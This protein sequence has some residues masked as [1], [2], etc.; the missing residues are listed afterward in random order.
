[1]AFRNYTRTGKFYEKKVAK[2]LKTKGYTIIETG[3]ALGQG[4][5]TTS[6]DLII[7]NNEEKMFVDVKSTKGVFGVRGVAL[8][9]LIK[10]ANG[11]TPAIVFVYKGKILGLFKLI[12][13]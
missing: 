9:G 5:G 3:K 8:Q 6:Y 4:K 7:K 12:Q 1:M 10:K 2:W 13:L 11:G